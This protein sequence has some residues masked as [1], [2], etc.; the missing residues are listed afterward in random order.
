MNNF[1]RVSVTASTAQA[2]RKWADAISVKMSQVAGGFT[3][4]RGTGG[5]VGED[6]KLVKEPVI[7][8]E[9]VCE[10]SQVVWEALRELVA[11]YRSAC[12]QEAVL[13]NL[14]G[15]VKFW[16]AVDFATA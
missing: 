16:Y 11:D 9:T 12:Q 4:T 14:S 7:F 8:C 1:V 13:V 3:Q 6:G 5:W 10:D 2:R 15:E